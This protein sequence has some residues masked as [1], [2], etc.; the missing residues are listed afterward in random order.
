MALESLGGDIPTWCKPVRGWSGLPFATG[1]LVT[2]YTGDEGLVAAL[3]EFPLDTVEGHSEGSVNRVLAVHT[4]SNQKASH[5]RDAI[6]Y[7]EL[8]LIDPDTNTGT[9]LWL[10]GA[11]HETTMGFS[12]RLCI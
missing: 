9:V 3:L 1:C 2:A 4:V 11:R 5:E 10:C 6:S 7:W 12:P 8:S